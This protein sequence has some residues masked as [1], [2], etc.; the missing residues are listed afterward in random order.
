VYYIPYLILTNQLA[1]VS[2]AKL[3]IEGIEVFFEKTSQKN[4][5]IIKADIHFAC[6]EMGPGF[7]DALESLDFVNIQRCKAY[8]KAFP[9]EGCVC[10]IKESSSL[11]SFIEFKEAMKVFMELYD[12]W[13]SVVDDLVK[14]R[15][16]LVF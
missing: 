7:I 6:D 5:W 14:S 3:I 8:L 4:T 16:V 10:L 9:K 15:G 2:K 12:F 1:D 13:K 11:G